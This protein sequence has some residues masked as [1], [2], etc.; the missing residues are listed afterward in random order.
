MKKT[1][2]SSGELMGGLWNNYL[3][4]HIPLLGIAIV[5]MLLEGSMVGAIS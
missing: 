1:H 5:F 2:A 4:R 3:R